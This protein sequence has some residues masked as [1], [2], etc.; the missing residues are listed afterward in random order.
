MH[1][2]DVVI[3]TIYFGALVALGVYFWK[4]NTSTEEYFVGSRSFSGWVVGISL[5]GT[6]ISSITFLAYPADAFKTTWIRFTP[7]IMLLAAVFI[8]AFVFLPFFRRGKIT[9]AYEYLEDRFGPSIRL[10]GAATFLFTELIR[11]SII[12]FLLSLVLHEITGLSPTAVIVMAGAF[13]VFYTVIGGID[14][15]IWTDVV[16]VVVFVIG[17]LICLG[18]IIHE[19]PG[20]LSQILSVATVDGKFALA[21]LMDGKAEAASWGLTVQRKTITM[22]LILGLTKW[23][24]H[25][26]FNQN[27]IQRYVAT[28]TTAEA[29]KAM[30]VAAFL[31]VPLWAFFFFLGTSLYVYFK[32]FPTDEAARMLTGELKAEQVLPYFI[33]NYLPPGLTGLVLAAALAAAMSSLDSS[34][35]AISTVGVV[36]IY[37]R[38]LVQDRDDRHYLRFAHGLATIAGAVMILGAIVLLHTE[39]TTIEDTA[40]ILVSLFGGG[41]LG[42]YLIGFFTTKGDARAV[43]VGIVF[44][45]LFTGWAMLSKTEWLPQALRP[46]FDLYYTAIFANLAMFVAGYLAASLW[47]AKHRD[48]ANLTVWTQENSNKK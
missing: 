22:M 19:L 21:E 27:I 41:M 44:T 13:V 25:Y 23:L 12:L 16:Q 15:V 11:I 17:G 40:L 34:I 30:F 4:K 31:R 47:P 42:V 48:L 29:R 2:L 32:V 7:N 37:R 18:V 26:C 43:G 46:P 3:M 24:Q 5:L 20:G 45:I 38:H 35:N 39:T 9:S 1:W 33:I 8:A 36:D 10:Y 28:K 14:T 6:A